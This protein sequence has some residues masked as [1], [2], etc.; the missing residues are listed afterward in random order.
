MHRAID[1][2]QLANEQYSRP[3]RTAIS[4][5]L[6]RRL[7]FD[8][9]FMKRIP[10]SLACSD[11]KSCYDR[12][13][14][15]AVSLAFQRL[16]IPIS[17]IV[18]MFDSIQ[19]MVHRVRTAF[20]DS[21]DT[22]GGDTVDNGYL[23]FLQG[24]NQGNGV[25]PSGW[26]ILSSVIL[27]ALKDKG[28]GMRFI[29]AITKEAFQLAA[30]AFVDDSDLVQSGETAQMAYDLMKESMRFWE[31]M[32]KQTGGCLVPEKSS[33][34]LID[35]VWRKGKFRCK[36]PLMDQD[37]E[38]TTKQGEVVSL[39]RLLA[40]ESMEMLGIHMSPD[41]NNVAQIQSM[42]R[43]TTKWADQVRTRF[44]TRDEAMVSI[45][46]SLTAS[47]KYPLQTL[48]L[49]EH[50]CRHIMAPI[51]T[52]GLP[53]TGVPKS[54]PT[55]IRSATRMDGGI[56]FPDL[57]K[58][59]GC[60]RISA[61]ME[62]L[63]TTTPTAYILNSLVA[64]VQLEAGLDYALFSEHT[65]DVHDW[66]SFG[67]MSE[68]LRFAS[69]NNI[70]LDNVGTALLPQRQ[71]DR[72][73]MS[74]LLETNDFSLKDIKAI[75]RCR[76]KL[77][78]FWLSDLTDAS[79][80]NIQRSA[81]VS[82]RSHTLKTS[83]QFDWPTNHHLKQGD[84]TVWRRSIRYLCQGD[85]WLLKQ[86]LGYWTIEEDV[87]IHRWEWFVSGSNDI[88]YQQSNNQWYKYQL[89]RGRQR[90]HGLQ[91]QKNTRLPC[92]QPTIDCLHRTEIDSATGTLYIVQ[93]GEA[94][95]ARRAAESAIYPILECLK[96]ENQPQNRHWSMTYLDRSDDVTQ[97]YS[98][99]RNGKARTCC[100]GSYMPTTCS[101]SAAWRVESED[102]TQYLEGGGVV[103]G[104]ADDMCSYRTELGG[105]I[106]TSL[107]I[108]AMEQVTTSS[109]HITIGCDN[110]RA[111]A[112]CA[113]QWE[114]VRPSHKHFDLIGQLSN[115]QRSLKNS[116]SL[117]HVKAHQDSLDDHDISAMSKANIRMDKLAK[118]LHSMR[119]PPFNANIAGY[120]TLKC[121]GT[122]ICSHASTSLYNKL[123][124]QD[125]LQYLTD[126][127]RVVPSGV[128]YI[129]WKALALAKKETS[130]H[131]HHFIAKWL[132]NQLPT[133]LVKYRWKQ[134]NSPTCKRCGIEKE[135]S[136]HVI[137]CRE[138]T[139]LWESGL[140]VLQLWMN[141]NN[142]APELANMIVT[143]LQQWRL[144]SIRQII[145]FHNPVITQLYHQQA[146]IGWDLFPLGFISRQLV[147]HQ[148]RYFAEIA[149]R[150]QGHRWAANLIKELWK[151][152]SQCWCDRNESCRSEDADPLDT[153]AATL[154]DAIKKEYDRGLDGLSNFYSM[155]FNKS[156]STILNKHLHQKKQWYR[157]IKYARIATNTDIR[158][159][160]S[161]DMSMRL[162]VG[163]EFRYHEFAHDPGPQD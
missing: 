58:L 124:R 42:R 161:Y 90:R 112:K 7:L 33:W 71:H 89:K 152:L 83:N 140:E 38:A 108:S 60:S 143:G 111:L 62:H 159:I 27:Q 138:A 121:H 34:Y 6:N 77:G 21:E 13:V 92:L 103:P 147:D 101:G 91:F 104:N 79:G 122:I 37:L 135:T 39:R 51:V 148:H 107:A 118:A 20:G 72:A 131:R 31:S 54:L 162:Y 123:T 113:T 160:F 129:H 100:D 155:Y 95:K 70:I 26:S 130:K 59:Q 154:D 96:D 151:C 125:F 163:L 45:D 43:K 132:C 115:I 12:V 28:Y 53:R 78:A 1:T 49:Q 133:Q 41:G 137:Q 102:G 145:D 50:E 136:D 2:G 139:D 98:D 109:P 48:T 73:I 16:G 119:P 117:V 57:Y 158:D 157:L 14:H 56:G 114:T 149:S 55:A 76:M 81:L 85:N 120:P 86:P 9:H 32:I 153:K 127:R 110:I 80:Y 69:D 97:L 142:T 67:W 146:D 150:K 40:H 52:H 84:W 105:L 15:A 82:G 17:I 10:Y 24:F 128:K 66:I 134:E 156:L 46:R 29:H 18:T 144:K 65:Y 126:Q 4:H 87:Y 141:N 116:R 74:I 3:G 36:N 68:T 99:F 22:Y 23:E 61:L 93:P 30:L 106:G 75:N 63:N 25:G 19:R 11:L 44:I 88:L 5:A 64:A 8:Y 35:Y 94:F 47:L